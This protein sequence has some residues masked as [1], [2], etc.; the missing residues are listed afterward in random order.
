MILIC[1][2]LLYYGVKSIMFYFIINLSI[3]VDGKHEHRRK[4]VL[5]VSTIASLVLVM[6]V[7]FCI[8]M[9]KKIYKG[10]FLGQNTFLLHKDYKHLQT[11]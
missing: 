6:L 8:Y 10:K 11:Q 5:V 4:V 9:I 1:E 2:T 3:L 7:A